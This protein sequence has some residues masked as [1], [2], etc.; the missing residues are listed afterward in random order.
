MVSDE[1]SIRFDGKVV[2]ITGAA[3]GLGLA[4]A[5]EF[6]ERGASVMLT[7]LTPVV[8]DA[9]AGVGGVTAFGVGNVARRADC[10]ALVAEVLSR[11]GRL[12]VLVNNAGI[13]RDHSIEK[14]TDDE[15]AAVID[16]HLTGTRNMT[17]AAWPALK[18][19]GSGRLINTTSASGL[20]GNFGQTNYAAAKLGIVG[21]TKACVLEGARHGIRAH[22]IAPVALTP[23]T[24]G[25][26]SDEDI[27]A[28]TKPEL[29]SPV[30]TYLASSACVDTGLIIAAGGGYIAR[31]AIVESQGVRLQP[32]ER[33]DTEW[34]ARSMAEASLMQ[35]ALEPSSVMVALDRAF[36]R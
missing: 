33:L 26:W 30:V 29:V 31:I 23:M 2:L 17:V 36:G 27:K 3:G 5:R 28:R 4:Y 9:A 13:L 14:Q 32:G 16:V 15:W 12:D 18:A 19:S 7:D 25:L 20:Y 22:C 6:V 10:D 11:W 21:F 1:G 24:D 8:A 34:V 35:D